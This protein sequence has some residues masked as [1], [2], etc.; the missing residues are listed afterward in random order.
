RV[1]KM[2]AQGLEEEAKGLIAYRHINALNTVGYKEFFSYMDGHITRKKAIELVK[3]NS[4]RYAKRQM[5][6]WARDNEIEWFHPGE[7]SGI[8]EYIAAVSGEL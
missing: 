7:K 4:R 8:V 2:V 6:W 1:D 5:T 3:R